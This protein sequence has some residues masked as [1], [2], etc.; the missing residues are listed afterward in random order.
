MRMA[1]VII[2]VM[3]LA[4]AA[5]ATNL[6][7][8][9]PVKPTVSFPPNVP[10][11]AR[12]GGDTIYDAFVIPS[13]PFEDSGTTEGYTNDYDEVCPFD[14]P[15]TPDVC[16][17]FTPSYTTMVNIDL[18]YSSYD[19]K[20]YVWDENLNLVACNDDYYFAPPCYIYSSRLEGVV[21]AGGQTYYIIVD[22]YWGAWGP[23]VITVD[24]CVPFDLDC[25]DGG[26][27]EGE[28][29]L[30]NGYVDTWNGGCNTPPE[31]PFEQIDGNAS[32]DAILCGVAG[33]YTYAGHDYRD[34]D[35]YLLTMGSSGAIDVTIQAESSTYAFELG[36]QDCG[37]VAV[38]QSATADACVEGTM[39]ITGYEEG[40]IVWFWAGSTIFAPPGGDPPETYRYTCWFS[41]LLA[42]VATEPTSW[43][44]MKALFE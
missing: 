11:P 3:A 36:P 26:I 19:T 9:A 37:N 39:A 12:Q 8:R 14:A 4:S 40:E 43:S 17:R 7:N 44:T 33:W 20:V 27:P 28:P 2:L 22:G 34:T 25:P 24:E 10:D 6:G 18:C 21:L 16:Y 23:Y 1:I 32:G 15:N 41:G 30:Y 31:Y 5:T 29:D 38:L 42:A 13:L 35:W